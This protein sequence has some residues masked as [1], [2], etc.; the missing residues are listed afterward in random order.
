ML[1]ARHVALCGKYFE[2]HK[3]H[4]LSWPLCPA[5][6]P[7]RQRH[8][9]R[10]PQLIILLTCPNAVVAVV[11]LNSFPS[12]YDKISLL[13]CSL[14]AMACCEVVHD[15]GQPSMFLL[16]PAQSASNSLVTNGRLRLSS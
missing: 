1:G 3:R 9:C 15:E 12:F 8:S 5:G 16:L 11:Y 6:V 4:A 13:P 14:L 10:R 7:I 2:L